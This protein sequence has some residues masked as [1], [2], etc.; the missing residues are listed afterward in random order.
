[1]L[2]REGICASSG[3]ACASGAREPSHVLQAIGRAY[4]ESKGS[5]RFTISHRNTEEEIDTAVIKITDIVMK[6]RDNRR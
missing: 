4:D 5:L 6:L 1:M 2:D 3:S